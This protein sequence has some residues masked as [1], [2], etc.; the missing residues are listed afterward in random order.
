MHRLVSLACFTLLLVAS[1]ATSNTAAG[2][3]RPNV[4]VIMTDDQGM[5]DLGCLGNPVLQTPNIDRLAEQ[6]ARLTHF[7]VSPVCTPTRASLLTGRYAYRTRAIDTFVG[8]AMMEPDEVTLAEILKGAGYRTGIFGKWHLGDCYPMRP[9][10]QGFDEALVH[11]GGGLGQP[12][13]PRENN[14]RYTDAILFHNGE[15]VQSKGYCT[16]VFFDAAIEFV[17]K[18]PKDPFFVFVPTNAPHGPLHDVPRQSYE[19]YRDVDLSAAMADGRARH[20]PT[21]RVFAMIDNIDHNVGRLLGAIDALG[22]TEDTIVIYLHDNGP[23][24]AGGAGNRLADSGPTQGRKNG[25]L[26]GRKG[27]VYEGGIRSPLFVRWPRHL[28]PAQIDAQAGAHIDVLPTVLDLAGVALPEDVKLDGCSLR[29]LLQETPVPW[30]E[31][32]LIT[33]AHR[34]DRPVRGHHVAVRGARYKLVHATGFGRE[35]PKDDEPWQ[36]F[37]LDEDP[38]EQHDVALQLPQLVDEMRA[39]YDRWF[40][41]VSTTR[42]DNYDPP[43]IV[44][45]TDNE[46]VTTLTHQDWRATFGD[47]WGKR[48]HWLVHFA[49][50]HVYNIEILLLQPIDSASARLTVGNVRHELKLQGANRATFSSVEIPEGDASL[51]VLIDHSGGLEAPYQ[52]VLRRY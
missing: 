44:I 23:A 36:L 9:H 51:E 28:L 24:Q 29:P 17:R 5:G 6:S 27:D 47:G 31:R 20:D 3:R 50:K 7:Y 12:S 2:T 22:L 38:A 11:R 35:E 49:R 19:K 33:Q 4:I 39:A 8:R 42:D 26:R 25:G 13:E 15:Q 45:G 18:R 16:D 34:G 40:D 1:C 10:D 46:T 41:D 37:D 43:R 21:A 48:G 32:L 14:S 52:V 30:P